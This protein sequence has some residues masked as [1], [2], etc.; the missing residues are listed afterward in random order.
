MA[1]SRRGNERIFSLGVDN[2]LTIE[3]EDYDR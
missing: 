1:K 3:T 2:Y